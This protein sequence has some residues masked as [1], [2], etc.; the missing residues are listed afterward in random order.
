IVK[1]RVSPLKD[2]AFSN[3]VFLSMLISIVSISKKIQFFNNPNF[4]FLL[5]LKQLFEGCPLGSLPE[6]PSLP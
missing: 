5:L 2:L 3:I 6:C 1:Q 4:L